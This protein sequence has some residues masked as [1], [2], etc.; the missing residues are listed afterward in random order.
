[1]T[2]NVRFTG[3][4]AMFKPWS[5]AQALSQTREARLAR[6]VACHAAWVPTPTVTL[7][8]L[9]FLDRAAAT[10]AKPHPRLRRGR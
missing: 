2:H 3:M 5:Y 7:P 4:A 9:T 8:T 10:L 1:M 6:A